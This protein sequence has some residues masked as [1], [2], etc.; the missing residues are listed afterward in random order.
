M[1]QAY[2]FSKGAEVVAQ[3]S[4]AYDTDTCGAA[5]KREF[6]RIAQA[7]GMGFIIMGVIG[8]VVKLSMSTT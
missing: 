6:L 2:V 4:K 5:D 3:R 7:V 8:Y 1:Q